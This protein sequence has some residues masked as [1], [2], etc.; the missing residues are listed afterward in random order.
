[1]P[2]SHSFSPPLPSPGPQLAWNK[3]N[4]LYEDQAGLS[5]DEG[6]HEGSG[7][8]QDCFTGYTAEVKSLGPGGVRKA[9]CRGG[10]G[11]I[12]QSVG[13]GQAGRST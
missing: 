2:S 9:T 13:W 3:L 5:G 7:F 4:G 12:D 10:R 6:P 8:Q 11:S 1:M